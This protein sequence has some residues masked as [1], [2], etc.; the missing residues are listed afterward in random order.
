[1]E[2]HDV[3]IA[4]AGPAGAACTAALHQAGID[5]L[6]IERQ[7]LPRHK[8]CSGILFGQ[9][10]VLLQERFGLLP[11]DAVYCAPREVPAA[12]IREWIP[13]QGFV[14]YRWELPKDGCRF[15][16]VYLNVRRDLFDA[17]LVQCCGVPVR[18]GCSVRCVVEEGARVAVETTRGRLSCSVLV[19]ADGCN[20]RV[21]QAVDPAWRGTQP[22]VVIYQ[23]YV[24]A[25]DLGSLE[26][27]WNVFFLPEVGDILCCVHRKGDAAVLCVGGFKGRNLLH[28][29]ETFRSFLTDTF[30][31]RLGHAERAEG[32][33]Q[34]MSPPDL[35]RD[36][37]LLTGDAAGL[38]YLNGEALSCAID[39]GWR[40]GMAIADTLGSGASPGSVY[41]HACGDILAHMQQCMQ[42][43]HFL[44][45]NTP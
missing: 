43:L 36:R 17:W 25:A 35:G 32:C 13:A 23:Q 37:I 24:P 3:I 42:Q 31:L 39:S 8:T 10:Q 1:M 38:M 7:Q 11:P 34:R 41:R 21:R 2:Y 12:R 6:V 22:Q 28:S 5:A 45:G 44:V 4:G 18:T 15:P 20:S 30:D 14:P 33:R 40:A 29:M 19:G 9:T 16:D 26:H 27:H